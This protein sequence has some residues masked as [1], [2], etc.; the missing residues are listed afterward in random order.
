MT[1]EKFKLILRNR[2]VNSILIGTPTGHSH[3]RAIMETRYGTIILQEAT[4]ANLVRAYITLKTHPKIRSMNLT[5]NEMDEGEAKP[6]FAKFQ[7]LEREVD[8]VEIQEEIDR[9]CP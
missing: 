9:L 7:L 4:I 5:L 2:D 1:P 8:T 3:I 6:G